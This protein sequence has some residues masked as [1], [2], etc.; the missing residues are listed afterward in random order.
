MST[1]AIIGNLSRDVVA[2]A[3]SRPGGA[4]FHGARALARIGALATIVARCGASDADD[5]VRPLEALGL[6]VAFRAGVRTSAFSFHYEGDRRVMRVDDIGDSWTREDITGWA[7][8][9]IGDATWVQV[10]ALLRSDFDADTLALLAQEHR[11]LVDAQG[12]VR[13]AQPGPL[14]RDARVDPGVFPPLQALKLNESEAHILAGGVEHE[15][16]RALGV[17]EVVVTLGSAGA[18]VVTESVAER[19]PP[20]PVEGAVDPTGAGDAFSAAYVH[21]RAGGAEPVDAA[22]LANSVAAEL[23]VRENGSDSG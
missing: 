12:L 14:E 10:G 4:V 22:R 15:R 23:V 18:L 21:A 13:V 8:E 6:P 17:P 1:V 7:G 11:L 20:V 16:L 9:A 5:L 3:A 19:I 2:G